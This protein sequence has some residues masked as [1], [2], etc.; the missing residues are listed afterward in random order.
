MCIFLNDTCFESLKHLH[1][2]IYKEFKN[3]C[4]YDI[5][6]D[7]YKK[8]LYHNN[9]NFYALCISEDEGVLL[10]LLKHISIILAFKQIFI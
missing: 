2:Q 3:V 10:R 7:R 5:I 9:R 8:T 1:R 6:F 4:C